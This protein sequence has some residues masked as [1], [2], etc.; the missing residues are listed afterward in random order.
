MMGVFAP[1]LTISLMSP[2]NVSVAITRVAVVPHP[3]RYLFSLGSQGFVSVSVSGVRINVKAVEDEAMKTKMDKN[4]QKV[5]HRCVTSNV[6][7]SI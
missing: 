5:D 1:K 3:L 2:Q 4:C 6:I 7:I